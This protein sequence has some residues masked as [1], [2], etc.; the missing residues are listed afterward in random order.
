[1]AVSSFKET[2]LEAIARTIANAA[3][4]S[5][6]SRLFSQCRIEEQGGTPKWERTLLAL[7]AR[8]NTDRCGNNVVAFI[9]AVLDPVRFVGR[10]DEHRRFCEDINR[11]LSFYGMKIRDDGKFVPIT[12]AT[13]V[14][15]AEERASRLKSTLISR[16]VHADVIRFCRAE[17]V[18]NNYFHAVF[19]ATKSVADK[20]RTKS[21]LMSDGS[22]LVDEAFGFSQAGYPRLA[23]NS[24]QTE[25]EK[26]EH[27]G[28]MN[29]I[30]GL[31]GTFRN[32]TAHAPKIHWPIDEQ[33]AL[34][35]LTLASL[36]HR[37]LDSVIR[38]YAP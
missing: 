11:I 25:T 3:T 29:L 17:L 6:F 27:K 13:T 20:I 16:K 34:D 4:H 24:L 23:F 12:A 7:R 30:K 2:H 9:Q 33:D 37:R 35:I 22:R 18:Q 10:P 38:T 26:S 15:E 5:E 8:Q 31:F 1:M 21:D 32:T 36:I 28:L 14:M 19:E